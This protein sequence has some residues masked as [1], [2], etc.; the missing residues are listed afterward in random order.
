MPHRDPVL[1]HGALIHGALI[2]GDG[3]AARCCAHLLARSGMRVSTRPTSPPQVPA[4]LL[5]DA[6]LSLIRDIFNA[7]GLFHELPRI[8]K[9]IVSWGPDATPLSLDHSGAVVSAQELLA[10]LGHTASEAEHRPA[11]DWTIFAARPLPNFA[12]EHTF[13]SRM[14]SAAPAELREEAESSACWIESL[15][16]GWL[17]LITNAPGSAW[18]LSVGGPPDEMLGQSRLVAHQVNKLGLVTRQFPASPAM[19]SPPCAPGW[20]ACGTAAMTFDPLCG[21]G[22][23]HA[24]REA[25]LASAVLRALQSAGDP[26]SLL[27]HYEARLTAAFRKHLELCLRYYQTGAQGDWWR[28]E[29]ES[30]VRGLQWCN[31]T[32]P[33]VPEFRYRL[34]GF[35]LE[36]VA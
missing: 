9:R 10:G 12:N 16:N 35:D 26:E 33:E 1:I 29:A 34:N 21:D 3:V 6:A 13:G 30:I 18:L 25:V 2:H 11:G 20:L 8:R 15:E 23:A 31:S 14:A 36:L 28:Q 24:V 32:L 7:P 22:T 17:F 4:I 19:T 5:S 27:A